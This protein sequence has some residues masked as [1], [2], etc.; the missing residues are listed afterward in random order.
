MPDRERRK[1]EHELVSALKRDLTDDQRD[2]L[3]QLERFGFPSDHPK[4]K[5]DRTGQ[6]TRIGQTSRG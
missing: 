5:W 6:Q 2:T 1:T 4:K 3:S